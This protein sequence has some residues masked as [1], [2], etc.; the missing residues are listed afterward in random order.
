MRAHVHART[1]ACVRTRMHERHRTITINDAA[2][3][4]LYM[5]M[6]MHRRTH[7]RTHAR[8]HAHGRTHTHIHA[9]V[10][11]IAPRAQPNNNG[12]AR[13]EPLTRAH[14]AEPTARTRSRKRVGLGTVP[15][16]GFGLKVGKRVG[17]AANRMQLLPRANTRRHDA[18]TQPHISVFACT[19]SY[20]P[21]DRYRVIE[22]HECGWIALDR[23]SYRYRYRYR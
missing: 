1:R 21:V 20:M 6:H 17:G 8:T 4:Q 22:V 15:R 7:T 2:P 19:H 10:S 18:H 9:H 16:A 11:T 3:A 14:A 13:P 5:H 12:V 23:E